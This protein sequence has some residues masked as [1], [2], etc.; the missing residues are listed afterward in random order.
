[1]KLNANK[2]F[3]LGVTFISF[4]FGASLADIGHKFIKFTGNW[5][6][7]IFILIIM[8]VPFIFGILTGENIEDEKSASKQRIIKK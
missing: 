3:I 2:P 5:K 4:M 7:A 8:V 6:Q 1:M